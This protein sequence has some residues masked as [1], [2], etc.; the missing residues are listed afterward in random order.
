MKYSWT[1]PLIANCMLHN[2]VDKDT[3]SFAFNIDCRMAPCA[4]P[5]AVHLNEGNT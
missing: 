3:R 2:V 4:H 5:E 1:V